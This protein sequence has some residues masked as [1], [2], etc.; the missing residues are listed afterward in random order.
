MLYIF[1]RWLARRSRHP[2]NLLSL[3][4]FVLHLLPCGARARSCSDA[5]TI[6]GSLHRACFVFTPLLFLSADSWVCIFCSAAVTCALGRLKRMMICNV[7]PRLVMLHS[8]SLP[9]L[10]CWISLLFCCS[11]WLI[12]FSVPLLVNLQSV[13]DCDTAAPSPRF[14]DPCFHCGH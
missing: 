13:C 8:N 1:A 6:P 12:G 7:A 9:C 10:K 11:S 3:Y 5:P 14:I 2:W 4:P